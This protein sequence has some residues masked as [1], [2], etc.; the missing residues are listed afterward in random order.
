MRDSSGYPSLEVVRYGRGGEALDRTF[1]RLKVLARGVYA[2]VPRGTAPEALRPDPFLVAAAAR[3]D[4]VFSHHAALELLGAA[5]SVWNECTAYAS[6]RRR[7]IEL[8]GTT[9]CFLDVPAGELEVVP[10]GVALGGPS[11][12]RDGTARLV[13][14]NERLRRRSACHLA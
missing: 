10:G 14:E 7:P 8:D 13:E 11:S 9:V 1:G 2:V 4:A 3:P 6:R 5:H 12:G